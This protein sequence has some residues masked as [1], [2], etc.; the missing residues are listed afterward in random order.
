MS[1]IDTSILTP[2]QISVRNNTAV[3]DTILFMSEVVPQ[4]K[5][6]MRKLLVGAVD[7]KVLLAKLFGVG[8]DQQR[9]IEIIEDLGRLTTESETAQQKVSG[10]QEYNKL[11]CEYFA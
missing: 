11:H 1:T 9:L 4:I 8:I 10:F 7:K 5:Q 2:E 3:T 6:D